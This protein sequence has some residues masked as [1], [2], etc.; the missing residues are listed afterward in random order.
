MTQN[1]LPDGVI[2]GET[3]FYPMYGVFF[4]PE[5]EERWTPTDA[6]YDERL[7][8]A[9]Q[10][11][12]E[13]LSKGGVNLV[14]YAVIRDHDSAV[15]ALGSNDAPEQII[16]ITPHIPLIPM[17]NKEWVEGAS[18]SQLFNGFKRVLSDPKVGN[19]QTYQRLCLIA[20]G[21]ASEDL[22]MPRYAVAHWFG[23][24]EVMGDLAPECP[25]DLCPKCANGW[26]THY[27]DGRC[28]GTPEPEEEERRYSCPFCARE[29]DDN[30]LACT[31]DDCP[32]IVG[33]W[34]SKGN[35]RGD[36]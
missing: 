7:D 31:S 15:M 33:D 14:E 21:V 36:Q 18:W 16:K 13:E 26:H 8:E 23:L 22:P 9:V 19:K 30:L 1:T 20:V 24:L 17:D 6:W 3:H 28:I 34:K 4:R 25:A 29:Y 5:G 32:G 2:I 35:D 27:P 11:L 12:R 10:G